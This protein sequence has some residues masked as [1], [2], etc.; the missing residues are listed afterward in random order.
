MDFEKVIRERCS[1]RHF[2]DRPIELD[3]LDKMV[4]AAMVAPTAKNKQPFRIYLIESEESIKKLDE[5]TRCRYNAP[6]VALFT[7]RDDEMWVNEEIPEINSGIED[8]SIAA[9]HFMLEAQ[10]LGVDTCWVNLFNNYEL[11]KAFSLN[12]HEHAVLLMPIGYRL[13]GVHP[14]RLHSEKKAVPE[15][16]KII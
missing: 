3:K 10:N 8:V 4:D 12:E 11:E 14:S 7:Y 15:L 13:D 9:C 5:L 2:S 6:V 1:V 16:V